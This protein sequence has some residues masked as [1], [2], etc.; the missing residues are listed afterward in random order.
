[1]SLLLGEDEQRTGGQTVGDNDRVVKTLKDRVWPCSADPPVVRG[2]HQSRPPVHA[3]LFVHVCVLLHH[4]LH[5][6]QLPAHRRHHQRRGSLLIGRVHLGGVLLQDVFDQ[7]GV[8]WAETR[9]AVSVGGGL[10]SGW[11]HLVRRLTQPESAEHVGPLP[12]VVWRETRESEQRQTLITDSILR[13]DQGA[14]V[15]GLTVVMESRYALMSLCFNCRDSSKA[16][17]DK[18]LTRFGSAP[19]PTSCWATTFCRNKNSFS[20]E[21][22]HRNEIK[23]ATEAETL[24]KKLNCSKKM[25]NS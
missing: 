8:S 11:T 16:V 23:S 1:M 19:R 21:Q 6:L 7:L 20:C 10:F 14:P 13:Q 22:N 25:L 17:C 4:Q 15:W 9:G 5:H 18:T 24:A 2:L 3:I 12:L